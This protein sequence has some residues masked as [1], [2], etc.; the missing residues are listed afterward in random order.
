[1]ISGFSS[2]LRGLLL[3]FTQKLPDTTMR[4]YCLQIGIISPTVCMCNLNLY[5]KH[6]GFYFTSSGRGQ[7]PVG[8][9]SSSNEGRAAI[10]QWIEK[11]TNLLSLSIFLLSLIISCIGSSWACNHYQKRNIIIRTVITTILHEIKPR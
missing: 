7:I 9:M 10:L 5:I 8:A 6:G 2:P 4:A 11:D 1:M 3:N